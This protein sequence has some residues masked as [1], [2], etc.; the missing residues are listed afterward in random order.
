MDPRTPIAPVRRRR[1][2]AATRAATGA[3]P[4]GMRGAKVEIIATTAPCEPADAKL[5]IIGLPERAVAEAK[6]RLRHG[7]RGMPEHT[8]D[9]EVVGFP[10]GAE[11]R[12]LDLAM[13]VAILRAMGRRLTAPADAVFV[14]E[15]AQGGSVLPVRGALISIDQDGIT[16]ACVPAEN[17]WE[18]GLARGRSVF[19]VAT[20]DDLGSQLVRV[21]SSR[22]APPE[23]SRLT[24][25]EDLAEPARAAV[26]ACLKAGNRILL[27]GATG[28]GKERIAQALLHEAGPLTAAEAQEVVR[29]YS[30]LGMVDGQMTTRRPFR[31][32]H[33]TISDAGLVG[34]GVL[35]RPGELSMAHHGALLLGELPEFRKPAVE[36]LGTF[37][38]RGCAEFMRGYDGPEPTSFYFPATPRLVIATA[39]PCPCG[40]LGSARVPVRP[41]ADQ[42]L[43]RTPGRHGQ[44]LGAGPRGRG[45]L[46]IGNAQ[47]IRTFHAIVFAI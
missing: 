35:A 2:L 44:R 11:P 42:L 33:H 4:V 38:K 46:L 31:A 23:P 5:N 20:L 21:E 6:V 10:A 9:V 16:T 22:F 19:Q 13:A 15:L 1:G 45:A 29:I 43:Q 41:G 36:L 39:T 26:G 30:T 40:N 14:G 17:A 12:G 7:V 3:V 25:R 27:V 8:V 24:T 32:P 47:A 37:L 18:A 28:A 34:G